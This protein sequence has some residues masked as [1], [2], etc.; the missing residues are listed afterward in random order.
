MVCARAYA[1][2]YVLCM[3]VLAVRCMIFR[4]VATEGRLLLDKGDSV[5]LCDAC[6]SCYPHL[7]L[8]HSITTYRHTERN[9]LF[10]SFSQVEMKQDAVRVLAEQQ[11]ML[12]SA[13]SDRQSRISQTGPSL[14][15]GG[16]SEEQLLQQLQQVCVDACDIIMIFQI[17]TK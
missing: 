5:T 13:Q 6:L 17:V 11:E 4:C 7:L 1:C 12:H 15:E 16:A 10:A 14:E 8:W 2:V 9:N 3:H